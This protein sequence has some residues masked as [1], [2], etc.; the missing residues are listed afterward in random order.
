MGAPITLLSTGDG[1]SATAQDALLA[2][3]VELTNLSG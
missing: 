1:S 3:T 2:L